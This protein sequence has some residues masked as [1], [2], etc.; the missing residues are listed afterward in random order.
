MKDSAWIYIKDTIIFPVSFL[1][2]Y[3]IFP[4]KKSKRRYKRN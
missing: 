2:N 4:L 1:V 3:A